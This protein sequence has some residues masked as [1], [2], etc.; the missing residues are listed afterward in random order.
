MSEN[1]S[2][3]NPDNEATSQTESSPSSP[4]DP[5]QLEGLFS[6]MSDLQIA[7]S[8]SANP[9]QPQNLPPQ[10][11]RRIPPPPPS[12]MK[13]KRQQATSHRPRNNRDRPSISEGQEELDIGQKEELETGL[14]PRE[15]GE[16]DNLPPLPTALRDISPPPRP[17]RDVEKPLVTR[18]ETE[19]TGEF[20]DTRAETL[21][22]TP[23][24]KSSPLKKSRSLS[25]WLYEKTG[26]DTEETVERLRLLLL[27]LLI[28]EEESADRE[29]ETENL[30]LNEATQRQLA[31]LDRK[32]HDPEI[33]GKLIFPI[34]GKLLQNKI[35]LEPEEVVKA[36]APLIDL[37]IG[38]RSL[39]DKAAMSR[40][41]A[42]IIPGALS[43][44]IGD[45]PDEVVQAIAPAIG[46]S[47]KEQ[48]RLDKEAMVD[49][50]YPVIGNSV[51]K[52]MGEAIENINKQIESA[53]SI[54]GIY[55]KLRAR[56]KGVSEGEL[57]L[58]QSIP[59]EV[60]AAFLIH[61]ESGL[62][63]AEAQKSGAES[64][65][66]DMMAGMLTAIRSFASEC[67]PQ[68]GKTSELT[69][70]DYES[71]QIVM[72]VAGYCYIATVTQGDPPPGFYS[73][74]RNTLSAIILNYSYG[75]LIE[76][77]NG[78]PSTI[79]PAVNELLVSLIY[80]PIEVEPARKPKP[81]GVLAIALLLFCSIGIPWGFSFYR[82]QSA[83]GLQRQI[84]ATLQANEE[85]AFYRVRAEARKK[86][87]TLTGQVPSD[88]LRQQAENIAVSLAP[89]WGLKNEIA[90]VGLPRDPE[91]LRLELERQ[92]WV[93]NQ[94]PG[95]K[96]TTRY[97]KAKGL[98]I[99]EGGI[100]E[101][102]QGEKIV[103]TFEKIPGVNSVLL[104]LSATPVPSQERICFD[105][106][107]LEISRRDINEKLLPLAEYLKNNPEVKLRIIGHADNQGEADLTED[108]APRRA[109]VV[110]S[111][112][113]DAG[114][115]IERLETTTGIRNQFPPGVTT[116]DP[117]WVSRCVRFEESKT[118]SAN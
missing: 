53:F 61:K 3:P 41:L 14:P 55:R 85:L 50:L 34:F 89:H 17:E 62:V 60:Q 118:G 49:A 110:R 51:S 69:E 79:P 92:S 113:R 42:G 57:L 59:F 44:Q 13:G 82:Q 28:D 18:V 26:E 75:E 21:D 115:A 90:T 78:D 36:F 4:Q 88:R 95:V 107:G 1:P 102:E 27:D 112:L 105:R 86:T 6:L 109:V 101:N 19:K 104:T 9:S 111:I 40:A 117:L 100:A 106:G 76:K 97:D 7:L 35:D 37:I 116:S 31:R 2:L 77:Y 43:K 91:R 45:A 48:I 47:I 67:V 65:E 74:L 5:E 56:L 84:M 99:V 15:N 52:Y 11:K 83:L 54:Q 16:G 94:L 39:E 38:E 12:L 108:L 63:I 87:V 25:A 8:N 66:A 64:L 29:Q 33:L 20:I 46:R 23:L 58:G 98:A 24:D 32:L 10:R 81:F 73:K 22:T 114:V 93:F 96:I 70:V 72:E 103:E 71:F 80:N 30:S 68:A